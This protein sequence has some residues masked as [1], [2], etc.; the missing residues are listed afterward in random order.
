MGQDSGTLTLQF[1]WGTN[2]TTGSRQWQARLNGNLYIPHKAGN[3][4]TK[5]GEWWECSRRYDQIGPADRKGKCVI[6]VWLTRRA[7]APSVQTQ[8]RVNGEQRA[9]PTV[10]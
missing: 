1:Y 2:T 6:A 10:V 7:T 5:D 4:P 9:V 8:R 3:M